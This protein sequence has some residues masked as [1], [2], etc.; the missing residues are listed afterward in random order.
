MWVIWGLPACSLLLLLLGLFNWLAALADKGGG[1]EHGFGLAALAITQFV[2]AW[3]LSTLAAVIAAFFWH[4][5]D[6]ASR[7]LGVV[8]MGA[9]VLGVVV[10]IWWNHRMSAV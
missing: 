2:F 7:I 4:H 9:T 8:A 5:L 3:L 6:R 1:G 10:L